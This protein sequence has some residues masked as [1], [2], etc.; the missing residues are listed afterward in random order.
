VDPSDLVQQALLQA[1]Q[2]RER[3][4]WQGLAE[5]AAYLRRVLANAMVDA[6]RQYTAGTRNVALERSLEASVADSAAQLDAWLAA[7]HSSPEERA[8]RNEQLLRLAGALNRLPADQRR[9]V[10]LKHLQGQSL[11]TVAQELGWSV[12]AVLRGLLCERL[13]DA[14]QAASAATASAAIN[15]E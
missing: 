14:F 10:E 12:T 9:A 15:W 6:V 3:F 7:D 11:E 5:Q 4:Q 2:V 1:H 8:S 13:A